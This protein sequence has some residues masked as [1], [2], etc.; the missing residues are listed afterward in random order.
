MLTGLLPVPRFRGSQAITAADLLSDQLK[1][2]GEMLLP[3]L[4][5]ALQSNVN[6]KLVAFLA[7]KGISSSHE[8][9]RPYLERGL[10]DP[11]R[12]VQRSAIDAISYFGEH[13]NWAVSNLLELASSP[14]FD[15]HEAAIRALSRLGTN[16]W[17]VRSR[18]KQMLAVEQDE[19]TSTPQALARPRWGRSDASGAGN[20]LIILKPE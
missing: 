4:E 11:D 19:R 18:L 20:S 2:P 12:V 13:G 6:Q 5:P 7:L 3:L 16:S 8:L 14:D 17:P 10:K 1:P 9:A 15:S